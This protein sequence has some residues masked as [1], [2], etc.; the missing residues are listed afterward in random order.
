MGGFVSP[1]GGGPGLSARGDLVFRNCRGR[2]V[3]HLA[4]HR[5]PLIRPV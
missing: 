3:W 5:R 1:G 2:R 4:G